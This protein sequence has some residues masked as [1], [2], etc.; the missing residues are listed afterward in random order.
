M[1]ISQVQLPIIQPPYNIYKNGYTETTFLIDNYT[2][3]SVSNGYNID[4]K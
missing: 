1:I 4:N 2:L 3:K